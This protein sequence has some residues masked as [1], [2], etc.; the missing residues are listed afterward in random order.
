MFMC[1][2]SYNISIKYWT[3]MK[4]SETQ[5]KIKDFGRRS[6]ERSTR[7]QHIGLEEKDASSSEAESDFVEIII[8]R[9]SSRTQ[10][11]LTDLEGLQT[12]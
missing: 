2:G 9:S 5:E 1:A 10:N 8:L 6:K 12:P 7:S 11:T 4:A 3:S